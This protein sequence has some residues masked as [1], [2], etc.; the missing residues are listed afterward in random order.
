MKILCLWRVKDGADMS[1]VGDLL[2]AEEV[3]AW[4]LVK[5]DAL[6]EHYESDM[7]VPAISIMEADSVEAAK[8]MTV[9]LPINKAGYL[10]PEYFPLRP[11]SNWEVLFQDKFKTSA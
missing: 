5:R 9:D 1:K 11:F 7:P 3:F 4:N 10:E 2:E 8:A 6:R